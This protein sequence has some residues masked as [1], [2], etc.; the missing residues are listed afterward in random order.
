MKPGIEKRL[1]DSLETVLNLADGLAVVDTMD[2]NYMNFSQSFSCP[3]CG[4][5]IDEIEPRSF[6]FNNPFGACP[7]C[8]G[9]GY[10]MEFDP[11]LMIPD[12]SLSISEGAI[13]VM[14]WQSCTDK[15]SFTNAILNALCREYGF[16][17]DTP[18]KDYPKKIQDIIPVSYTHLTLPTNREV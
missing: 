11:D 10:K 8:L 9:L 3:D 6:S 4:V 16:D 13:V 14:G 12:K 18:F 2:G 1:T 7:E 5:S 17:L 15:S